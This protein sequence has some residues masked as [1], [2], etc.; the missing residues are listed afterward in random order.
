MEIRNPLTASP[1]AP[2][3]LGSVYLEQASGDDTLPN[4]IKVTF[5]GG[6]PGT[7]LKQLVID[8]DKDQNGTYSSGEVFFDT[9]AGGL[10]VFKSNPFQVDAG[11]TTGGIQVTSFTVADGGQKL[12]INFSGFDVGD[13]FAFTI[14]VD[15]AQFVDPQTGDVDVNAV[16]EGNEFQRSIMTG[17]FVAPHYFDATG[18]TKYWDAFDKNFSDANTSSGTTLAL[19]P[20]SYIPP[21][22]K[23]LTDL[24]A[25]AVLVMPQ[26]PL[27]S[28]LAGTVYHDQNLDHLLDNNEVGIGNVTLTL[29]QFDGTN[30][31]STGKT[32][33]TDANGNYKFDNLLPGTY[34]V[35]ET[36]PNGWISVGSQPGTVDGAVDGTSTDVDTLSDAVLLGGQDGIHYNFG[37]CLPASIAGKVWYDPE[38]DCL[39]GVHDVVLP[40]VQ[41]DLLNAQGAVIATTTTNAQGEYEFDGLTP[42]TYGVKEHQPQG[43]LEGCTMAG[44]EGG[45]DSVADV[46]TQVTL[47]SNVHGLNYDFTEILPGSIS[48]YVHA[49]PEGDCIVG[50]N[51]IM[52][53]GVKIDLLDADGKVLKST[54]TDENG[55]YEFTNLA[56]GEYGVFEHQ[57]PGY[58]SDGGD[59]GSLGGVVV[60]DLITQV[61]INS[62]DHGT[63]Y[64]FCEHLPNSISGTVHLDPE[65]D[66]VIGPKDIMLAG[67]QVDLLNSNNQVIATTFTNNDGYYEFT[68]LDAGTYSVHYHPLPQYFDD[69]GDVG[70]LGGAGDETDTLSNIVLV[71]DDHGTDY[72]FCEHPPASIEGSVH[73]DP[74]GD[75]IV[76]PHDIMLAGVQVD[77]LDSNGHVIATTLTNEQG[78]YKFDGLD[79]GTYA[80]HYHPLPQY[81][82]DGGDVGSLGGVGD[83][84][85]TLSEVVLKPGDHGVEYNFCEHPPASIQ[86]SVHLDPEGDCEIGPKDIM[87]AGVKVDLLDS[88]GHVIATTF[89]DVNGQYKFDGL[90]QG[91]YSV[92]YHPLAQYF[93]DGGDVGSLGGVGDG[94]DILSEIVVGIGDHGVDYNFCEHPGATLSGYVFQD[95]PPIVLFPGQTLPDIETIRDGVRDAGDKPIAGVT[96]LLYDGQGNPVLDGQGHQLSAVTDANGFYEFTGLDAGTYV[97]RELQPGGYI[98]AIDTPGSTGGVAQNHHTPAGAFP[99]LP[100]N[101]NFDTIASITLGVGQSSV[102]NNFSEVVST[103]LPFIPPPPNPPA[104]KYAAVGRP[105]AARIYRIW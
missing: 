75:C 88:E 67:V 71:S 98:D 103:R 87:L 15:E 19:P 39:F 63:H 32:T 40:G 37:E 25:G 16:V 83:E 81:F 27:P 73:L 66:C 78:H 31:V 6:A 13:Q 26:T 44:T 20:D 69:G 79:Q 14:D 28:S 82:D 77:L 100:F 58:Y 95:G 51:D 18:S 35:A 91:T 43:Y 52:L 53:A 41:I 76:G 86:G 4:L 97:V 1:I 12:I 23:D 104:G 72:N 5:A 22:E 101:T 94:T 85:D 65:G 55:Y 42:G 30:W 24:T 59:V 92:Q 74:E 80:V 46:I 99:S 90:D 68:G 105:C 57:P 2:V 36:Q 11:N 84:T 62:D 8:G 17:T 7:Q 102:E 33:T 34:R 89:T 54:F 60:G 9:A 56:P 64:D 10:G 50:P 47:G 45:D 61:K 3:H 96:V 93:D 48:G 70:S 29:L 49:D 38:N 21:S